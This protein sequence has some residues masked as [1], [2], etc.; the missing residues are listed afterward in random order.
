MRE[1]DSFNTCGNETQMETMRNWV[2]HTRAQEE[3]VIWNERTVSKEHVK[4]KPEMS[5]Q[6][7]EVTQPH[8]GVTDMQKKKQKKKSNQMEKVDNH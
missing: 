5:R 2:R 6:H 7:Q 3:E 8:L 4:P 1:T